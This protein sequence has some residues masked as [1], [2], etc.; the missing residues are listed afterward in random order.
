M[1]RVYRFYSFLY[2]LVS[3][4][5]GLIF[6]V[7]PIGINNI[8]GGAAVFCASHSGLSDPF[9]LCLA[10][11]R[12]NHM[13][14]MAKKELFDNP[15]LRT[16]ILRAGT[17]SVDRSKTDITAIKTALNL[18]KQ[19]EKIVIFPEGTRAD[20]D[21]AVA[22]K[23]GAIRIAEKAGVPIVPVYIP[24]KKSIWR[25]I[26]IVIGTPYFIN[27]EKRKLSSAEYDRLAE[28]LMRSISELKPKEIA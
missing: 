23:T 27:P 13:H 22:A 24:R 16:I 3:I 4:S 1:R 14:M 10:V 20:E 7:K 25:R 12:K 2:F 11:K 9:L 5:L 17:F 26:P 8:P 19:G 15:I 18:L 6:R 28:S 21:F